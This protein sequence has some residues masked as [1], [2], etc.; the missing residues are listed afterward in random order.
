M[1]LDVFDTVLK[2]I[3]GFDYFVIAIAS[4][5]D[6]TINASLQIGYT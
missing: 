6:S 2:F 5:Y 1:F 3:Q 4:T